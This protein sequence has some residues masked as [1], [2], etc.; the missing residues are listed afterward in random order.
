VKRIFQVFIWKGKKVCCEN[1]KIKKKMQLE[2]IYEIHM[3]YLLVKAQGF[4]SLE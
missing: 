2:N 3:N 1:E 4:K